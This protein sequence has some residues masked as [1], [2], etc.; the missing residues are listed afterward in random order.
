MAGCLLGTILRHNDDLTTH[1]PRLSWALT[2]AAGLLLA[3]CLTDTFRA[4][5]RSPP[6]RPGVS[7]PQRWPASVWALLYLLLDVARLPRGWSLLPTP[8]AQ[9]A[10]AYFLHPIVVELISLAG[11]SGTVL[12][13]KGSDNPWVVVGG[14]L[15][16]AAFVCATAGLLARLGLRMRL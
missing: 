3:G 12:A 6:L 8:P 4:S 14:S 7:A 15:G 16:M 2:F 5:T 9:S 11:L 1:R 10:V 13:Y